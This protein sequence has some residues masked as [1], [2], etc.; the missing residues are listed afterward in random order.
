MSE[1]QIKSPVLLQV[2]IITYLVGLNNYELLVSEWYEVHRVKPHLIA[3]YESLE[4]VDSRFL[5]QQTNVFLILGSHT[6]ILLDTGSGAQPLKALVTSLIEDRDLVVIN[7]HNHFDHL[8]NNSEFDKIHIHAMD[9]KNAANMYDVKFLSSS[10]GTLGNLAKD[11]TIKPCREIIPLIGGEIFDLGGIKVQ[12]IYTPGHTQGSVCLRTD[13]NELFTGDTYHH[14]AYYLPPYE[15]F[16][17][18][19]DSLHE[20]DQEI[21]VDTT[22]FPAHEDYGISSK[23]VKKF[24][25]ILRTTN[26][27]D[28]HKEFNPFLDAYLMTVDEFILIYPREGYVE[29]PDWY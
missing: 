25:N 11:F 24:E 17:E 29:S 1:I 14:G 8:G 26:F 20:L 27:N 16:Q 28:D 19:L 2:L 7:S 4:K 21:N 10:S 12:T 18:L 15:R 22:L 9:L 23:G 5:T 13:K 3:I 6:A